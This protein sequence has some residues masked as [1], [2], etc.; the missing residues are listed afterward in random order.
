MKIKIINKAG[1]TIGL[2][3]ERYILHDEQSALG[4]IGELYFIHHVNFL[5]VPSSALDQKF[6]DLST[7]LAG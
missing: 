4:I 7:G 1:L 2:L 6:F 3:N 5:V